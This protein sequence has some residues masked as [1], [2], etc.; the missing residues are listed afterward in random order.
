MLNLKEFD[1]AI[2][3]IEN[4]G[5]NSAIIL[6][7]AMKSDAMGN[8]DGCP[9]CIR[10]TQILTKVAGYAYCPKCGRYLKG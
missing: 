10:K 8:M 2:Y 3:H 1:D 6:L 4:K 5:Y 9:E 7:K